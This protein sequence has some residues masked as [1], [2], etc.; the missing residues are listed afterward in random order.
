MWDPLLN[1]FPDSVQV[2]DACCN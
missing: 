1:E 2:S